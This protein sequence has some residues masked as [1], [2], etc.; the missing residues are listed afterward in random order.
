MGLR[1]FFS[2]VFI[3]IFD[4]YA[5]QAIK[6]LTE[7]LSSGVR[8][9]IRSIF[10]I[11]SISFY[12]LGLLAMGGFFVHLSRTFFVVTTGL[13]FGMFMAKIL[14]IFPL[15]IEDLYRLGH[16]IVSFFKTK[17]EQ[18]EEVSEGEVVKAKF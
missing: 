8:K 5:Y 16:K 13:F 14:M 7:S 2:I 1:I 11:V 3:I 9:W 18:L 6:V 4:L 12:I 15:L 17:K 10:W